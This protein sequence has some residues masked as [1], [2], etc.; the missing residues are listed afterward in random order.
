MNPVRLGLGLRCGKTCVLAP[1]T[2]HSSTWYNTCIDEKSSVAW[3]AGQATTGVGKD[4]NMK[5]KIPSGFECSDS[6]PEGGWEGAIEYENQMQLSN[7]VVKDQTGP[8]PLR[9]RAA[10]LGLPDDA[11][12]PLEL[13]LARDLAGVELRAL[14]R[15]R[16]CLTINR[17][18]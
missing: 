10:T 12:E 1:G 6:A 16:F 9:P 13:A 14:N 2:T 18:S 3:L 11:T 15:G 4:K 8:N 17:T 7:R 5:P